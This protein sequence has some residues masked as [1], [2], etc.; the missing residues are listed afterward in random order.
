MRVLHI[1]RTCYPETK[2]GLEQA[3]RYICKGSSERGI[4]NTIL[5]LGQEN[6]EYD[7][8]GSRIIV[9]K[10]DFEISS[11]GF[12]FSLVSKF[13][14]L[15]KSHDIIHY[16]YPWPSGDI[17]SIFSDKKPSLVS[18]Q[19]DIVKQRL[20]KKLYYP[21]EQLFLSRVDRIIA[22]SP[23][24]AQTSKN[25]I[26]HKGKVDIIPLAIDPSTYPDL[27]QNTKVHWETK[28]GSGFFLF[29][30]VLRYYKGLQFLL[31]AAK[32]NQL[33]VVIAGDGPE[34][35]SLDIYIRRHKLTN[36]KMVGF[37]SEEDKVALHAL[38]KAFVFPSHLRSE[39]FGISLLEAQMY[40][41]PIISSDIGTGSSY[42]NIN[43]KTGITVLPTDA[44]QLSEAMIK[45]NN[46]KELCEELGNGASQRFK[47]HFTEKMYADSYVSLYH[48][49]IKQNVS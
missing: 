17:L 27:D 49:L 39:A 7:F 35:E 6:K 19:S 1:Y 30:G 4:K 23:Q 32:I 20:L 10:K 14:K 29:V 9:I 46:N 47:E 15:S 26:K 18:Y 42:V 38:S 45:L 31:E 24:Y 8:E 37:I 33:P 40:G 36:V 34:R 2:G 21:L 28:V 11:N 43:G 13:R 22:S 3:I 12:S 25:L 41:K 48:Q 44:K 16:Q 5:T